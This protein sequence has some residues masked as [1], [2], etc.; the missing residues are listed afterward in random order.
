MKILLEKDHFWSR[1][2]YDEP[3]LVL[4]AS[5]NSATIAFINR[6]VILSFCQS[7]VISTSDGVL[8]FRS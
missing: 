7:A 2:N 5:M 6:P 1:E 8:W 3:C 4:N